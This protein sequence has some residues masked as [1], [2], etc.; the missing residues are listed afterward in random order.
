MPMSPVRWAWELMRLYFY[1]QVLLGL[2][3]IQFAPPFSTLGNFCA[4]CGLANGGHLWTL[5]CTSALGIMACCRE[6]ALPRDATWTTWEPDCDV[7]CG[8]DLRSVTDFAFVLLADVFTTC[9]L[10]VLVFCLFPSYLEANWN[11]TY[12]LGTSGRLPRDALFCSRRCD[13]ITAC[14][15]LAV[16]GT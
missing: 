11:R 15:P 2:S 3:P 9:C 10:A 16:Q 7:T 12:G 4:T 13:L 14:S 5:Q 1:V 6:R 8:V